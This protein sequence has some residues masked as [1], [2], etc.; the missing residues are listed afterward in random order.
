[1]SAKRRQEAISRF[2]VPL[3]DN[4]SMVPPTNR[5]VDSA[6]ATDE[7][8]ASI[9]ILDT[10]EISSTGRPRRSTR[11]SAS[12]VNVE[13]EQVLDDADEDFV[14]DDGA[15]SGHDSDDFLNNDE[16]ETKSPFALKKTSKRNGKL[17]VKGKGKAHTFT[18]SN[19]APT[20]NSSGEN[21]RVMLL[22]LK[23]GALGLNLTGIPQRPFL[24]YSIMK[25]MLLFINL[26]L[27]IMSTCE[28]YAHLL[29][30]LADSFFAFN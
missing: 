4:M 22:S 15:A 20:F 9:S 10:P 2:S 13:M 30:G 18:A 23:A 11:R 24:F 1:M 21:P 27:P 12:S 25:L 3:E 5:E 6:T 26:Q 14:M 29:I 8:H 16:S 17:D 19:A 28:S 7:N